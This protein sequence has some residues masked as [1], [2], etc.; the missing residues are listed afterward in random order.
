MPVFHTYCYRF[1]PVLLCLTILGCSP[2]DGPDGRLR[3]IATF[4]PPAGGD[5]IKGEL[6]GELS[7]PG[8]PR[9]LDLNGGALYA[10]LNMYGLSVIDVAEPAQPHIATHLT[11][12]QGDKP[13]EPPYYYNGLLEKDRILVID[14]TLGLTSMRID[15]PL[16]PIPE[17][18]LRLDGFLLTQL[19]QTGAGYYL[20][21]GGGGLLYQAGQLDVESRP[22]PIIDDF[23]HVKQT[24]FY[25]PHYLLL[26]DTHRGGL[27]IFD[28]STP[29]SPRLVRVFG[30]ESLCDGM[31]VMGTLVAV[32]LRSAGLMFIELND[33]LKP[34]M[35]AFF[36]TRGKSIITSLARLDNRTL[37]AGHNSGAIDVIDLHDP[38][39][40]VWTT[41]I[42]A[43]A[44]IMCLAGR[45]DVIYAGLRRPSGQTARRPDTQLAVY[46]LTAIPN[47][48]K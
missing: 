2:D 7:L 10:Y 32:Q 47:P 3:R 45:D 30:A 44:G 26:A 13:D 8:I 39:Q 6:I 14:R 38:D 19:C 33:P 16:R 12:P 29:E 35:R 34:W 24:A 31:L 23:D 48:V 20:S 41:R 9:H 15:D 4:L 27:S 36:P 11:Q 43:S 46:R 22:R 21:A 18:S 28:I 25:P 37:L 17:W 1:F 42:L 5:Y 40:P